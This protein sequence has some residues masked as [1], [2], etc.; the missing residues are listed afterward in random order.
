ML[1]HGTPRPR[2]RARPPRAPPARVGAWRDPENY[3][4]NKRSVFLWP[5][6]LGPSVGTDDRRPISRIGDRIYHM[7]CRIPRFTE[8]STTFF[9]YKIK[10]QI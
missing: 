3:I 8:K 2:G 4:K 9:F 7:A 1:I 6:I 10:L 5:E